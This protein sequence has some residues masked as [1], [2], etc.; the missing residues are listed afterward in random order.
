MVQKQTGLVANWAQTQGL[1]P[2]RAVM[3]TI[4]AML[5]LGSTAF[6][7]LPKSPLLQQADGPQ[8]VR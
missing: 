2:Y 5:A 1:E 3:L 7:W 6:R 4:A 8:R